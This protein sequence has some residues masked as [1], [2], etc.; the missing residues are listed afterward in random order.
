MKKA[1]LCIMLWL[2]L[3]VAA[4]RP[5]VD[6]ALQVVDRY[7]G[8]LNYEALPRD[9]ML[10]ARTVVT[11]NNGADTIIMHRWLAPE[12]RVR[13]EVWDGGKQ[14]TGYCTNGKDRHRRFA[15]QLGWWQDCGQE[16]MQKFLQPFE[17]RGQLYDYKARGVELH[18]NG[19][20]EYH[21]Q[22]MHV[23]L[24]TQ[25]GHYDRYYFFEEGSGLLVLIREINSS[26]GGTVKTPGDVMEWKIIHEY[27]PIGVSMIVSQESFMREGRV[28]TMFTT[29][30][31]E[32]IDNLLFNADLR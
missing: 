15:Y 29:A 17:L 12:G 11:F 22:R 8:M 31:F 13:V 18:Y 23:V 28:Y 1:L 25:L 19:V 20:S 3:C 9:S 4:Q 24:A 10:V 2:P 14:S 27:Q 7:L 16:E 32:P 26:T 21:G 6:T 30:R 5:A